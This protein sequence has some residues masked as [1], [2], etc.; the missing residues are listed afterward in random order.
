MNRK[1]GAALSFLVLLGCGIVFFGI[2]AIVCCFVI[3]YAND[4]QVDSG[5][6]IEAVVQCRFTYSQYWA[7]IPVSTAS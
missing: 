4:F 1:S 7:G 2:V 5:G 3:N 6:G